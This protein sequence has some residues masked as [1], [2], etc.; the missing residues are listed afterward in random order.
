MSKL[1]NKFCSCGKIILKTE[2]CEC[3]KQ[4][5]KIRNKYRRAQNPEEKKFFNSKRWKDT[6]K[7]VIKRDGASCQRCLIKYNIITTA[8]LQ[9]HHVKPR[10]KYNG[11]NGYPDLRFEEGNLVTLCQACNTHLYIRE[12]LDFN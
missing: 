7:S 6:R 8:N 4:E 2:K 3:K 11:K 12:N 5:D 10:V 9:V 1:I